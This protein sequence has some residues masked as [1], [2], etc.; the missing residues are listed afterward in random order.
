MGVATGVQWVESTTGKRNS[1]DAVLLG[2]ATA[3]GA[4]M[5]DVESTSTSPAQPALPALRAEDPDLAALI[6]A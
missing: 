1:D 2:V 5:S 4:S 6:D 3:L